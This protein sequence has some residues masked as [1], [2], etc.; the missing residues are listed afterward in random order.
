LRKRL[1]SL[2]LTLCMVLSL[3]PAFS[4]EAEAATNIAGTF[5]GQDSDVFTALGFDTS[6]IPEGY[7]AETTDNPTGRDISLGNQVMEF[8]MGTSFG[9]NAEGWNDNGR[10]YANMTR[11]S[12]SNGGS[13]FIMSSVA[14]GDFDGDGLPGEVVHVGYQS[15]PYGKDD[16][17]SLYMRVQDVSGRT[18]DSGSKVIS[19]AV[20]P[21]Y[22]TPKGSVRIRNTNLTVRAAQPEL[23]HAWQNLLQVAAGDFDGDG[24]SEIAVYI[25]ESGKARISIY[26]Y[27]KQADSADNA[28][29]DMSNWRETWS[30]AISSS[31][32]SVPNMVSLAAGDFNR[33]GVD[34]LAVA[35]GSVIM[36]VDM[37][38]LGIA[39]WSAVVSAEKSSASVLWGSRELMLTSQDTLDLNESEFGDQA[40]VS[41]TAGDLDG[42]GVDELIATGQPVDDL[43]SWVSASSTLYTQNT[44]RTALT[45][46]YDESLGLTINGSGLLRPVDGEM[47][48]TEINGEDVTAWVTNNGF[49]EVYR[50]MPSMRTNAAVM[51]IEGADYRYLYLDSC[52][53]QYQSG[54]FTL[55]MALDEE[56]YD[57]DSATLDGGWGIG[58]SS[59]YSEYGAVSGDINGYGYDILASNFYD[60]TSGTD[61]TELHPG[62][63]GE[64]EHFSAFGVLGGVGDGAIKSKYAAEAPTSDSNVGSTALAFVDVDIDTTIMEYTGVHY[65]TY[66]DP[67]VLA[68]IAAAPYFE[69]VDIISDYDYA[70]QN[71]TSYTSISGEGE[72]DLVSVDFSFGIYGS[73]EHEAGGSKVEMQTSYNYTL[74]WETETTRTVEYELSF[75]TS[76]DEDAVAFF[77]IPT[78]N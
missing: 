51:N 9:W 52:M 30:Y 38:L 19:S 70:W 60:S 69:D 18:W 63:S 55:T 36:G 33:D 71:S 74:E 45:Y 8:Y 12:A 4:A 75:E 58:T 21:Y 17:T 40:R 6:E 59:Y 25:P 32:D 72:S 57:G 1:L 5:E 47:S 78:E 2:L 42:D 66:S 37:S 54:S 27:L 22:T 50:S 68:I 43:T 7:D 44:A 76:Q 65:L 20:T 48:T 35:H 77:S 49:D 29:L 67:K 3:M 64:A 13:G 28:W 73:L 34:D 10:T 61:I 56:H 26:K 46:L 31:A 41:L 62:S 11:P 14:A 15:I 39:S 53:Y 23:D 16:P 24:I